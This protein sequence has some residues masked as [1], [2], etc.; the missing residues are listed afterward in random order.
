MRELQELLK[1]VDRRV[2][3]QDFVRQPAETLHQFAQR[4]EMSEQHDAL[5]GAAR[6]YREYADVRFAPNL[7]RLAIERLR[8]DAKNPEAVVRG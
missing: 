3:K 1:V 6:W 2:K 8:N 4:M 5:V 7:D